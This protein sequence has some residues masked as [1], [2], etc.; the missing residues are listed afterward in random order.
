MNI[1][2]PFI[3]R[4]IDTTLLAIAVLLGAGLGEVWVCERASAG[5]RATKCCAMM[6]RASLPVAGGDAMQ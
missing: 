4:P 1:S 6:A 5:A 2:A 3:A